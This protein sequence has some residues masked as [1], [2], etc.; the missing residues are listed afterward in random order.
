MTRLNN[1]TALNG[2]T[3][4]Y[5]NIVDAYLTGIALYLGGMELNPLAVIG[6]YGAI[7]KFVLS[8]IIVILLWR[9]RRDR[10]LIVL[11]AGMFM[12]VSWNMM[13]IILG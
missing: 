5:F 7:Y 10:L 9:F 4:V 6:W 8:L 1:T 13:Q 11:N 3:F 12:V 2:I